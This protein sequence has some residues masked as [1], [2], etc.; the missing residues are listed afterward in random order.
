M[1][2]KAL[3]RSGFECT[4]DGGYYGRYG[5]IITCEMIEIYLGLTSSKIETIQK[6]EVLVEKGVFGYYGS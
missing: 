5:L 1:S 4:W 3:V 6:V 2:I